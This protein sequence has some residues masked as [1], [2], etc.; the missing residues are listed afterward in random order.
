M[1]RHQVNVKT[2]S[3]QLDEKA[4]QTLAQLFR[5]DLPGLAQVANACN[6]IDARARTA[7][8]DACNNIDARNLKAVADACNNIDAKSAKAFASACNNI[9]ARNLKVVADACNNIDV[10]RLSGSLGA[11]EPH[12]DGVASGFEA[13]A[14]KY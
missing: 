2:V 5:A 13:A 3:V 12:L 14:K 6:N 11:L 9:D 1:R 10:R 8:A 4:V 7:L